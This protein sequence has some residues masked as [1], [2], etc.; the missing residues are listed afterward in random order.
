[1]K[2]LLRLLFF[3]SH[4]PFACWTHLVSKR[5]RRELLEMETCTPPSS[6]YHR[7]LN[8]ATYSMVLIV[9]IVGLITC[10]LPLLMAIALLVHTFHR[11]D[12]TVDYCIR[13]DLDSSTTTYLED[14]DILNLACNWPYCIDTLLSTDWIEYNTEEYLLLNFKLNCTKKVVSNCTSFASESAADLSLYCPLWNN[15]CKLDHRM[16]VIC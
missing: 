10:C 8:G 7:Q 13:R 9:V 11:S 4:H 1:M 2:K 6:W 14:E 15:L 5:F 12:D 3:H 16:L